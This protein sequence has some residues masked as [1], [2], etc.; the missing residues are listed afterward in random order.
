MRVMRVI[1]APNVD[2]RDKCLIS[3]LLMFITDAKLELGGRNYS[4][5]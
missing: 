1:N 4:L 5:N 3:K 2:I